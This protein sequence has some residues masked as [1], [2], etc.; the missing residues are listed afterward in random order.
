LIR[1]ERPEAAL[2][3]ALQG[4]EHRSSDFESLQVVAKVLLG[5][6][7]AKR[8]WDLCVDLRTR[9]EWGGWFLT[10]MASAAAEL[11]L[12]DEVRALV[13]PARWFYAA[14]LAVPHDFNGRLA[15][16]LLG[17]RPLTSS[18]TVKATR[19]AALMID[20][21]QLDGGPLVQELLAR[22][23]DVVDVYVNERRFFSL[24]P[25]I[26]HC[27]GGVALNAWALAVRDDGHQ[28]WHVHPAG[29]ISGVYYVAA[30][31]IE[32]NE[33]AGVIEFGLHPFGSER[34]RTVLPNWSVRPE[35]GLL[36]LFPSHYA[37]RTLPTCQSEPRICVAFDVCPSK[38][39]PEAH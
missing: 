35:P 23:R 19:G 34:P 11:G 37:H 16:E 10:V 2:R 21:L 33:D 13:N 3:V 18:H 17:H 12:M 25:I 8:L 36:L 39:A 5:S 24:D 38:A 28:T 7:D 6:G 15:A 30:P 27:P 9:G 20:Q 4:L 32:P 31:D 1:L 29:W 26:A 22:I 14:S